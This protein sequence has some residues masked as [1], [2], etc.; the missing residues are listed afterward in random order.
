MGW[1]GPSL[2]WQRKSMGPKTVP[3]GTPDSTATSSEVSPSSTTFI[4]RV[5][6]VLLCQPLHG[7]VTALS[8]ATCKYLLANMLMLLEDNRV[9]GGQTLPQH[10]QLGRHHA[11]SFVRYILQEIGEPCHTSMKIL[12][13]HMCMR[14]PDKTEY[15]TKAAQS[16]V[17][18][19]SLELLT[20]LLSQP[21][22]ELQGVS[23][24]EKALASHAVLIKQLLARCS[25]VSAAARTRAIS[26]FAHCLESGGVSV[27]STIRQMITPR[28]T[29]PHPPRLDPT[30][31]DALRTVRQADRTQNEGEGDSGSA[32]KPAEGPTER[33]EEGD[34]NTTPT[35]HSSL[36]GGADRPHTPFRSLALTEALNNSLPDRQGVVSMLHRRAREEKVFVR[37]AALHA[38]HK[39]ILFEAPAVRTEDVEVLCERCRDKALLVRKQALTSLTEVMLQCQ[40]HSAVQ[41]A[42]LKGV[43][44]MVWDQETSVQEKCLETVESILLS[45]IVPR[46]RL[47]GPPT[48]GEWTTP[49]VNGPH[50][51]LQEVCTYIPVYLC[52]QAAW[53]VLADIAST[54]VRVDIRPVLQYWTDHHHN[55]T[56][57]TSYNEDRVMC[58]LYTLG[59]VALLCPSIVPKR[60]PM[61]VQSF[62]ASPCISS[63][64]AAEFC[65]GFHLLKRHPTIMSQH[66]LESIFVFND[67]DKHNVFNKYAQTDREREL[68][69]LKGKENHSQ[70]FQ[71]YRF[72]LEHMKDE[73]RFQLTSKISQE[74]DKERSPLLKDLMAFL[75]ELMKDYKNEIKDVLAADKQ[76]ACEVEYD[77]RMFENQQT[78]ASEQEQN[79]AGRATPVQ[80][81]A[82]GPGSGSRPTTPLA[83]P[84][85]TGTDQRVMTPTSNGQRTGGAT[86]GPAHTLGATASGSGSGSFPQPQSRTSV[87]SAVRQAALRTVEQLKERRKS[88]GRRDGRRLSSVKW[89]ENVIANAS[90]ASESDQG[91]E[92]K[93]VPEKPQTPRQPRRPLRAISTPSVDLTGEDEN[94]ANMVF[95]ELPGAER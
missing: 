90:G 15:R 37:K 81:A 59:V 47:S 6:I 69:S 33:R 26:G 42:W 8:T 62:I 75:R 89:A 58:Y 25:D 93:E 34:S 46:H 51:S 65:L 21:E 31:D 20:L 94:E 56:G 91:T 77:L 80:A 28:T 36:P 73:H 24:E 4:V 17:R 76:L 40:T 64:N 29:T 32:G 53:S 44:A 11:I 16:T 43:C 1:S 63:A 14:V 30:P 12:L 54:K 13:Q 85:R 10:L 88:S 74:L 7:D 45:N 84:A 67:Y 61:L 71:L 35:T 79:G 66:L 86:A 78:T 18:V 5:G 27:L 41:S 87:D 48:S 83:Q 9:C 2:M 60:A 22:R 70:R 23:E 19:F 92:D 50:I 72:M 52:V 55:I 3:C 38:L 68:F 57:D 39:F 95:M 82:E 49:Q